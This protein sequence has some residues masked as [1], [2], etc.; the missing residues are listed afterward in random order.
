MSLMMIDFIHHSI[1]LVLVTAMGDS[2]KL[3]LSTRGILVLVIR[4]KMTLSTMASLSHVYSLSI[5]LMLH[6]IR[7]KGVVLIRRFLIH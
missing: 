6:N 1:V 5:N 2:K 7:L 4:R 3:A